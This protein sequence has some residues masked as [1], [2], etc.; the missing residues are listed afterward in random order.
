MAEEVIP[1]FR[2]PDGRPSFMHRDRPDVDTLAEWSATVGEPGQK[3]TVRLDGELV[4]ARHPARE[5]R[6]AVG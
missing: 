5:D 3:P 4:D 1:H 2:G 6:A